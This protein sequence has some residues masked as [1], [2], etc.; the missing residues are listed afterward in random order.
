MRVLGGDGWS[1]GGHAAKDVVY[2]R[3][4]VIWR[5]VERG[6]VSICG[7]GGMTTVCLWVERGRR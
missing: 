2:A 3:K 6:E 1:G 5:S 4:V 7:E